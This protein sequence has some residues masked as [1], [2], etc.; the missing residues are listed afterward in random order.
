[1]QA[2]GRRSHGLFRDGADARS[3]GDYLLAAMPPGNRDGTPRAHRKLTGTAA[4][5]AVA[6]E[7]AA[8]YVL[9]TLP[10]PLYSRYR[11]QFGFSEIMLTVTYAVY[12]VGSLSTMF[13]LGRLSDQIGRR[14]V[15][16]A[17]I[18][19]A[20]A[21]AITFIAASSTAAL[22]AARVLSGLAIALSSGASTAWIVEHASGDDARATRLAIGANLFGL[23]V[24]PFLSG[25]LG[26][27]GPAPF[28]TPYLMFLGLL[29]ASC[30]AIWMSAETVGDRKPWRD[31]SLRPR[32]GVPSGI[33]ARFVSPAVGAFATFS[34]LGFYSALLPSL[35][36]HSIHNHSLSMA[37]AVVGGLFLV[38]TL[39]VVATPALE[40][41]TGMLWGLVLLIPSIALL[42]L[43]ELLHSLVLVL[44]GTAVAGV[45]SALGYRCGLQVVNE[46][47][48]ADRRSEV[49]SSY[50]IVCYAAVSLPVVGVGVLSTVASPMIADA[51]FAGVV[52]AFAIAAL[53]FELR[54]SRRRPSGRRL[55]QATT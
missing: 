14:P 54:L 42:A 12:V 18:G 15:V 6:A 29:L 5:W 28:R 10:T 4:A 39:T 30:A 27:Y 38:G 32:L 19:I 51:I 31:A 33:R 9:S 1:M 22:V 2:E 23:A 26:Q 35:L 3:F 20:A 11:E 55:A 24:G 37:G 36:Q 8:I 52:V 17:S 16:F 41:R 25:F 13:F 48:P 46:L 47:S 50:L 43:G 7:L 40:A 53:A 45:A 44:V 21:S 49:V 34:L